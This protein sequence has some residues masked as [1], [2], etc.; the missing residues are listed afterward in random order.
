MS[1]QDLTLGA[2]SIIF[3]IALVPTLRS[4]DLPPV[5]TSAITATGLYANAI[6]FITLGL[7]FATLTCFAGAVAWSILARRKRRMETERW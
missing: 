6:V 2:V 5:S 7:W 4:R 3:V 1:W